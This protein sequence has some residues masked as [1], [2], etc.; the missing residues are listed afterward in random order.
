MLFTANAVA[1]GKG[2]E[3]DGEVCF[4][5]AEGINEPQACLAV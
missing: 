3:V 2:I 5:P 1:F 4:W